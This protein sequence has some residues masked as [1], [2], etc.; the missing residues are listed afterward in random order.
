MSVYQVVGGFLAV[1]IIALLSYS[2]F[3]VTQ[4][5]ENVERLRKTT[6]DDRIFHLQKYLPLS[7]EKAFNEGEVLWPLD[8]CQTQA[9]L[10]IIN[11]GKRVKQT[12]GTDVWADRELCSL[13]LR[14]L[15]ILYETNH[16]VYPVDWD[17]FFISPDETTAEQVLVYCKLS[18]CFY[19]LKNFLAT[20]TL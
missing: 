9:L 16:V 3:L 1:A 14:F 18:P 8:N 2:V 11:V 5:D 4:I 15:K 20:V 10:G 6:T 12:G 13:T 19:D 17:L 7:L